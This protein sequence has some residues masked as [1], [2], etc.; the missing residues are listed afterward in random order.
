MESTTKIAGGAFLVFLALIF[1]KLFS[2]L[3]VILVSRLGSSIYGTLSLGFAIFLSLETIAV[4]GL[5]RGILRYVPYFR[6]KQDNPAIKGVIIDSLKIS[7]VLSLA[8][9]IILFLFGT[10]IANYFFHDENLGVVLKIFSF[11]LPFVVISHI[12]NVSLRAFEK[13]NYEIFIKEF[14]EKTLKFL[15]TLIMIL[16]GF[17]LIGASIGYIVPTVLSAFLA[18][19]LLHKKVFPLFWGSTKKISLKRELIAYS[20]PLMF[21]SFLAKVIAWTDVLMIGYFKTNSDV[22]IYNVA[23]PTAGLMFMAPTA[24]I[25]LFMPVIGKLYGE[26]KPEEIRGVYN[27]I[28]K[29][30]FLITFWIFLFMIFFAKRIITGFFGGNYTG[31]ITPFL[32]LCFGYMLFSLS[33]IC[34]DLLGVIK[35]TKTIF[36]IVFVFS[37]VNVVLN[38]ILIP[39]Y[40][41]IGAAIATSFSFVVGALALIIFNYKFTKLQP[42]KFGFLKLGFCSLLSILAVY[43][44]S[45]YINWGLTGLILIGIIYLIIYLGLMFAFKCLD[46]EDLEIFKDLKKKIGV[47]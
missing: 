31:A 30:V 1:G 41:L 32:I 21:V 45:R 34:S 39:R 12:L 14:L 22:G 25:Y 29:W 27:R 11:F 6:G 10:N 3:Y 26:N 28:N 5:D 9:S 40:N 2:Y 16:F 13:A 7:F 20:L 43:W 33:Y 36:S 19:Y 18:G 46:K 42:F 4:I 23:L 35:K 47:H 37:L 38:Y 17:K 8:G 24:L 44:F 15:L